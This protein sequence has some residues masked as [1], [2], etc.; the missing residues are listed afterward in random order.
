MIEFYISSTKYSLKERQTARGKVYDVIFRVVT[1]DG[2]E[3][4]KSLCGFFTKTAAKQAYAD[5]ITEKCEL[6]KNNPLKKKKGA[7]APKKVEYKL[8][9][10]YPEYISTLY[11]QTKESTIYDRQNLYRLFI[12]DTLGDVLMRDITKELIYKWQDDLW[13]SKNPRT[14]KY[15]SFEYLKKIRGTL[16]A[17]LSW[18]ETRYGFKSC[19]KEVKKPRRREPKKEMEIWTRS[20][21]E[22]FI[23]AVDDPHHRALFSFLFFVGCRKNEAL[24]LQVGDVK[25]GT[26]NIGKSITRKTLDGSAFKIT[27]TKAYKI[28]KVPLCAPIIAELEEYLNGKDLAPDV[29]LFGNASR[30]LAESSLDRAFRIYTEK[31]K[32]KKIR[33]HDLRHSFVSM[34]IHLGANLTVVADLI[35]DTLE[36]VTKTYGHMYETDKVAIISRI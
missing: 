21:F 32:V 28:R 36:Q 4:Q 33:I 3:K 2:N 13:S 1:L 10:L 30:P 26:V 8:A 14:G 23:K 17:F 35:G 12:R 9:D 31:A 19:M 7:D 25:D 24:A 6:V 27:S 34:L 11:N 18:A 20:E 22:Q 15:Y 29:Y 5:F 16:A